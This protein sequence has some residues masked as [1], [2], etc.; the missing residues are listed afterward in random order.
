MWTL[1]LIVTLSLR[2]LSV[3]ANVEK[4][5]FRGPEAIQIP[6]A[7]PN[8]EDLRLESLTPSHW[9]L[10]RQ[11]VASFP[12]FTNAKGSE[13][14]LLL[15]GLEYNQR[16]EV[17]ICW[18]A[19]VSCTCQSHDGFLLF[20][21]YYGDWCCCPLNCAYHSLSISNQQHSLLIP[22]RYL[23]CSTHPIWCF[24]LH[25]IL[26]HVN[27]S[28]RNNIIP[29]IV[30]VLRHKAI[31]NHQSS[32]YV[33]LQLQVTSRRTSLSCGMCRQ[34][35]LISVRS[36]AIIFTSF[37][38]NI[39]FKVL[40][41]FLLNLLPRSLLPTGIYLI[42]LAVVAWYLSSFVWQGLHQISQSGKDQE[43]THD[44][45]VFV[46]QQQKKKVWRNVLRCWW[47]NRDRLLV[48]STWCSSP[49]PRTKATA[50]CA[51]CSAN[52]PTAARIDPDNPRQTGPYRVP[53]YDHW[54]VPSSAPPWD[55]AFNDQFRPQ[56]LLEML[57]SW[58]TATLKGWR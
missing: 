23:R 18:V 39:P 24:H 47:R 35:T 29:N 38:T 33:S 31:V 6:K 7:H 37:K 46:A 42:I 4:T 48:P 53:C 27:Q 28:T 57:K 51:L 25:Y 30:M 1:A 54:D 50:L 43:R 26:N 15:D 52:L 11:V 2:I 20:V 13:T 3:L 40:D 44:S 22:L 55:S 49:T 58:W 41:P 9:S 19:T 10:R 16:Y 45:A 34:W 21:F 14:W 5:I 17:R 12:N 36:R 56:T 8:L 32:F